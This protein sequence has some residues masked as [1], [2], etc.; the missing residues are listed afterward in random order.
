MKLTCFSL[1]DFAP[2][3]VSARPSR[4]WM[5]QF[6]DRHP[7]RCL[8]LSIANSH[9]WELLCPIPVEIT[10]NGGPGVGD[11]TIRGLKALPGGRPIEHFC[12]SNFSQ[13]IATFH[14]DYIFRTER[15]WDLLATGPFNY[16]MENAYPLTGIIEA[17]WLPYPFTMN[18]QILRPGRVLFGENEPF[19]FIFPIPKQ[20]LIDCQPEIIRLTDDPELARQH[21]A[22]RA[23]RDEFMKRFHAGDPTAARQAWQRHYFVGRHPDGTL[24]EDH[25]NKLRL[26]PPVDRRAPMRLST[27]MS[28][29]GVDLGPKRSDPKWDDHSVLNAMPVQQSELIAVGRQRVNADGTLKSWVGVR[30][31]R[32]AN[33]A[34]GLDFLVADDLLSEEQCITLCQTVSDLSDRAFS[35]DQIDPYWNNR[36]IWF[37][38]IAM[39]R[40]PAGQVM[41]DAHWR[42]LEMI[43]EFYRL[44]APIYP[45]LLQIVQWPEGISMP[46]HA[47]NANPDGSPHAMAHR[48]MAGIL[49]LNDDYEAGEIYFT[50]LDV[51]VKPKRGMLVAA[52]AGF[53][54]EHAVLR[55]DAGV[56]YTMPFFLTFDPDKADR[57]L[58][59]GHLRR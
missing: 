10:W 22:F 52:T 23:S 3:I 19:C 57:R 49:Y 16:P 4:S 35:S 27:S 11:L 51:A 34:Q 43:R 32:S 46:P 1:H 59:E 45:D 28:M 58:L 17:D 37:A 5:D 6:T 12:R 21:D 29:V 48:A 42:A 18:W 56:R 2:R 30:V 26:K 47:D 36:F 44:R 24:A 14:L 9:G 7:Y 15:G 38:D 31:V 8:P 50:A 25:I 55:V 41:I 13:G 33:D 39:A 20:A 40:P 53:H 54:H